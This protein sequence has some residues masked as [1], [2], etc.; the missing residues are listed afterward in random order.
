MNDFPEARKYLNEALSA[1]KQFQG[2]KIIIET[3]EILSMV[4]SATGDWEQ[5]YSDQKLFASY[6]DSLL[7]E[8]NSKK[9]M[10]T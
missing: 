10:E 9:I 2:K 4:D 3:Y 6:H 5:A 8:E 1:A 7:N